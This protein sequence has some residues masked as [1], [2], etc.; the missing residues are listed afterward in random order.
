MIL[1]YEDIL[2]Y[3]LS[4]KNASASEANP[5]LANI[6]ACTSG[7]LP[8]FIPPWTVMTAG[9][10]RRWGGG[11]ERTPRTRPTWTSLRS[12]P[13]AR[14]ERTTSAEPSTVPDSST[15][16]KLYSRGALASWG[17]SLED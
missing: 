4:P 1:L 13:P 14:K 17:H 2:R 8:L 7:T 6:A 16:S 15:S 10:G 5:L 11:R 12:T 3:Y 9:A